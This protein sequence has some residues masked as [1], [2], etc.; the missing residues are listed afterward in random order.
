MKPDLLNITVAD[1]KYT[2]IQTGQ[3]QL[4]ALRHGEEWRDLTGDNLILALGQE[5]EQLRNDLALLGVVLTQ[6]T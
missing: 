5:I 4:K 1:G 6:N 3:G 2:L